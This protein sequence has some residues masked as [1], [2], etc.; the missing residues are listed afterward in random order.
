MLTFAQLRVANVARCEQVF[1]P[2]AAWS[3][4]DWATA[5][6]GE[7]GEVGVELLALLVV[8]N[9]VK[10]LRRLDGADADKDTLAER[11]RLRRKAV[12]E[13]ADVVIYADLQA[14][15][16][17]LDL[18]AAIVEKFN[19]VSEKRGSSITLVAPVSE[20]ENTRLREALRGA[21]YSLRH[22]GFT[23]YL[24]LESEANAI[25]ALLAGLGDAAAPAED[26]RTNALSDSDRN[27]GINEP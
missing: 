26:P 23:P 8:C 25:D 12:L 4:T 9:T 13:L 15:R 2:L 11:D 22:A 14:A 3:D 7:L 27:E 16:L 21:A 24:L 6:A 17:G 19:E 1:H 20:S 5:M 18:D 10:K